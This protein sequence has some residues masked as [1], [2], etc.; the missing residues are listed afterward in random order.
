MRWICEQAYLC[1]YFAKFLLE[2]EMFWTEV[3]EKIRIDI[4][5]SITFSRKSRRLWDSVEKCDGAKEATN[6]VTWSIRVAS[7]I[8]EAIHAHAQEKCNIAFPR[9]QWSAN[10]PKCYVIHT[11]PVFYYPN[12]GWTA[13][14]IK[15]LLSSSVR[16][17]VISS[18]QVQI[19][20]SA[21]CFN[22]PWVYWAW[23]F[24]YLPWRWGQHSLPK[25]IQEYRNLDI[26]MTTFL[27]LSF[28]VLPSLWKQNSTSIK[29]KL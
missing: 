29:T 5:C 3:V 21:H 2:W 8:S 26:S 27:A 17:P 10:A 9:Q 7:C 28:Y 23:I 6:D 14:V 11:L 15:L 1:Q 13:Q 18:C 4:L 12:I 19:L 24:M 16:R 20:F 22:T 25:R